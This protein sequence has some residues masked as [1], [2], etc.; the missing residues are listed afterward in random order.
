MAIIDKQV[1][2]SIDDA[3]EL[4]STGAM[5]L[6]DVNISNRSSALIGFRYWGGYRFVLDAP[7]PVGSTI[8]VAY[9]T[10]YLA[11][12]SYDDANINLHFEEVAAP[13]AFAAGA[14][15]ITLRDRTEES[16]PWVAN[17]LGV[18]WKQ[19]PSLV[20]PLQEVVDLCE[21]SEIVVITR[22]NQDLSKMLYV[23][24]WDL[25]DHSFAAWLHIEYTA[26]VVPPSHNSPGQ[27]IR[28][29]PIPGQNAKGLTF[30]GRTLWL[31]SDDDSLIYQI[32]P[33]TGTV[34]RS[35]A[36]PGG[37]AYG[38][39]FD[40]RTLW[41]CDFGTDLIYRIDP[42]TGTVIRSFASPDATLSGLTFDGRTL[43]LAGWTGD[44]IY[45]I[46]PETG[47]TIRSFAA[48]FTFPSGLTFDGRTLYLAD[49][50]SDLIY[51][52]DPETGTVIRSFAAG[53][54]APGDLTWD[55]RTLWMVAGNADT[56]VQMVI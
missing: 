39:A 50:D 34:I 37:D 22:P 51:Q 42:E 20:V 17:T 1:A 47:T 55:G 44:L 16:I 32:D 53:D 27:H 8:D 25:G 56:I 45:Q 14:F 5:N 29:F 26:P 30:D 38:L 18:G 7:I 11:S 43:W 9:L 24:S 49:R 6:T 40:G 33:E 31:S 36:T 13:V 21:S 12:T 19:S 46:D 28:S 15:D 2:A 10:V 48:P 4:E 23:S 3:H 54:A 41:H 52:I 35:F